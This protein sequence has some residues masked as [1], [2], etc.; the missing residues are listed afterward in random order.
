MKVKFEELAA[1][2]QLWVFGSGTE[3]TPAQEELLM[4]EVNAYLEKWSS[5]GSPVAGSAEIRDHRFL[6]IAARSGDPSGCSVDRIFKLMRDFRSR[7]G[8]DLLDSGLLF[9]RTPDGKVASVP[10]HE[11]RQLVKDGA[12]TA[13][14]PVFDGSVSRLED[15]YSGGFEKPA[16]QSW[17]GS[18]YGLVV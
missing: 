2:S 16:A 14:T 13:D 5:H 6:V 4:S 8:V 10:R 11:F 17:H 18:T 9:Y 7:L 12:V 15:L 1:D 3:L